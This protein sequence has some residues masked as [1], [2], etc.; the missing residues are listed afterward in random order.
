M[1]IQAIVC[2]FSGVILL[3]KEK[4][5][6]QSLTKLYRKSSQQGDFQF[7]DYFHFNQELIDY[8]KIHFTEINFSLFSSSE[9][10]N[11]TESTAFLEN[12]FDQIFTPRRYRFYQ[13]RPKRLRNH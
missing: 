7:G 13:N 2:D 3:P 11:L 10:Y 8:F 6:G 9:L 5:R 4:Y 12:I 1:S